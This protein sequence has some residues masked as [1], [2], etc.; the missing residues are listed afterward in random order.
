MFCGLDFIVVLFERG[1]Y[2]IEIDWMVFKFMIG[3]S[4]VFFCD[5][6]KR[7]CFLSEKIECIWGIGMTCVWEIGVLFYRSRSFFFFIFT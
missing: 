3:I 4:Y 2:S 1:K 5:I 6:F 7:L